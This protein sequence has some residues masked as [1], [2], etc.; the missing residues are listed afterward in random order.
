MN[1]TNIQEEAGLQEQINSMNQ[2]LDLVLEEIQ[3]QKQRR[4]EVEDL[5]M[6]LQHVG[7]DIFKSTV[8]ELDHYGVELDTEAFKDL[9][10]R[11][12]RNVG[13][14]N[15]LLDKAESM[16][17]LIKDL[18][19]IITQM[20]MDG[21][22]KMHELE[23]RGYFE[24]FGE[25]SSVSD[26]IIR[27][28]STEDVKMLADN[29][30]TI[31]ETVKNL[32]QPDMLQ[33]INNAVTVYKNLDVENIEEYSVWRVVKEMRTPEMK[34]GLGFLIAFLKNMSKEEKS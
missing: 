13:T 1:N 8:D 29:V 14:M 33:A 21:I 16:N 11:L 30:V 20:G 17:D 7:N 22:K 25:L 31:L 18:E 23:Q 5:V 2:K 3:A 19:P 27:H 26:N 15:E 4:Q 9:L 32:T 6:D 34:R 12:I 24:F 28:F 10:F